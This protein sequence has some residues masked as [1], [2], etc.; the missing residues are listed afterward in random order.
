MRPK[1]QFL[2]I[3]LFSLGFH[4]VLGQ[5][6]DIE[7]FHVFV[8]VSTDGSF[9]VREEID[10][11]FLQ[12]RRGIIRSIPTRNIVNGQEVKLEVTGIDVPDWKYQVLKSRN[13]VDIRIGDPDVF[14][15]RL[16]K[17]VI[18]YRI[19][20]AFIH[21]SDHTEFYWNLTGNDWGGDISNMTFE[22]KLPNEIGG[23]PFEYD[24]FTGREGTRGEDYIISHDGKTVKG[25]ATK[26]LNPGEGITVAINL[27]KGLIPENVRVPDDE[28]KNTTEIRDN[29]SSNRSE[30]GYPLLPTAILA[31]LF[32]AYRKYGINQGVLRDEEI[33]EQYYPPQGMNSAEVGTFYDFSVQSRDLISLIPKW[34]NQGCVEVRSIPEYDE[35]YFYKLKDLPSGTPDYELEFFSALFRDGDQ[36]FI[37]DLKNKFYQDM[38]KA[39]SRVNKEVKGMELYDPL[40]MHYF[41]RWP[42][43]V[44]LI[45]CFILSI[46]IVAAKQMYLTGGLLFL[47]GVVLLVF[48]IR[49]PKL[50]ERGVLL[51][52]ELR[53]FYKFLKNPEP[54]KLNQ[55]IREDDKYL[56]HVF[57]FVVAFGLDR[58]WNENIANKYPDYTPPPW[59]YHQNKD[60]TRVPASSWNDFG[61]NFNVKT[62]NSVFSSAPQSTG[63]SS[64]GFSGG[65]SG[66]GFGGGGGSSW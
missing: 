10:V 23:R 21:A 6:M 54:D 36:V 40:S 35:L 34:G 64:G 25:A 14:L 49:R 57:P 8:D 33:P 53:G 50:T 2:L 66:G 22:V 46:V 55:L 65:S 32:G 15:I 28:E 1:N 58:T 12:E 52:N 59:Y 13:G 5:D 26:T 30:G 17:Y 44:A 62:I 18:E 47:L 63:S 3:L 20:N 4:L 48:L 19:W 9:K 31:L 56:E 16:Q 38:S 60:G 42:N 61:T 39:S 29:E 51:H 45:L 27:P 41:K 37:G 11:R 43:I 24:A 7:R